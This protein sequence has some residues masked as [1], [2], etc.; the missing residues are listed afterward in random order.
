ML[1]A[2][3]GV[4]CEAA[5]TWAAEQ[6]A[7]NANRM[8]KSPKFVTP[9]LSVIL[10]RAEDPSGTADIL[11][12]SWVLRT[13]QDDGTQNLNGLAQPPARPSRK[14]NSPTMKADIAQQAAKPMASA[15]S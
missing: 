11:T 1:F 9:L 2:R 8:P 4:S 13:A 3:L 12:L 14:T 7:A 15:R 5:G 6:I 10:S